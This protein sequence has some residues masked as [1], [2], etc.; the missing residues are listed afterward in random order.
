MASHAKK[1]L[2]WIFHLRETESSQAS[3]EP[4]SCCE[5]FSATERRL[6]QSEAESSFQK[7]AGMSASAGTV[8]HQGTA[9]K[10]Q[11]SRN[12]QEVQGV[13][14][15]WCTVT[16]SDEANFCFGNL[17]KSF[18]CGKS[19]DLWGTFTGL[20]CLKHGVKSGSEIIRSACWIHGQETKPWW[21]ISSWKHVD[22]QKSTNCEELGALITVWRFSLLSGAGVGR[23]LE[24]SLFPRLC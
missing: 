24:E 5:G 13:A 8:R 21:M 10:P 16:F 11:S 22:K 9:E 18:V 14:E 2:L 19:W 17:E 3:W 15:G 23:Q 4:S 7:W 1:F 20:A 12:L 6:L